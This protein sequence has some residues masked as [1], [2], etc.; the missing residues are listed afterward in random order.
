MPKP[1]PD[2]TCESRIT[3]EII[4]DA[5]NS[6]ERT[7]SC[8]YQLCEEADYVLALRSAKT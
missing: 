8:Y 5:Y 7:L 1:R 4:V 6:E 2:R 3:D